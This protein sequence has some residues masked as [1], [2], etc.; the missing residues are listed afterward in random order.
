MGPQ[1][2]PVPNMSPKEQAICISKCFLG[3]IL[4]ILL[5]FFLEFL[6]KEEKSE[7]G[8]WY[9]ALEYQDDDLSERKVW[10][11]ALEFQDA[12]PKQVHDIYIGG[13]LAWTDVPIKRSE[14]SHLPELENGRNRFEREDWGRKGDREIKK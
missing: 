3:C 13:K 2:F 12:K 5:H 7:Q 14:T 8:L 6:P 1:P 4:C 10:S 11:N 9:D